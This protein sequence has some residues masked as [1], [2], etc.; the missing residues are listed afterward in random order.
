VAVVDQ[1]FDTN[2]FDFTTNWFQGYDIALA[3][4][5]NVITLRVADLAGNV[6]MTNFTV[7]LDY[8]T[9]TNAPEVQ[10]LWPTN[11]THL[12]GD[13]FYIRGHINDETATVV[14]QQVD[15]EGG[16][17]TVIGLVERNGRFWVEGL[18]LSAGTNE[19]ELI[20]TDAA[21]NVT[22]TNVSVVRS[23]V[24][25]TIT[26]TPTGES[27]YEPT[28]TVSGTISDPAYT[29]TV[30][31]EEAAVD[32]YGNWYAENVPNNGPGTA[33]FDVVV[34]PTGGGATV[35]L[36]EAVE[37]PAVVRITRHLLSLDESTAYGGQTWT[38]QYDAQYA[39]DAA[40]HGQPKYHGAAS[41]Y[42]TD[43]VYGNSL[44]RYQ[45]SD[46]DPL[47]TQLTETAG[48]SYGPDPLTIADWLVRKIPH[49]SF[50]HEISGS[51]LGYEVFYVPHYFAKGL[52]H[53]FPGW[54]GTEQVVTVVART[55]ETLFTGGKAGIARKALFSLSAG[56]TEYGK[57]QD[58]P[59]QNTP[60][61][62]VAAERIT[63]AGKTLGADYQAYMVLPE[64]ETVT[65][66]LRVQG[67]KHFNTGLSATK[68][69]LVHNTFCTALTNPDPERTSLGVGEYVWLFFD[70]PLNMTWPEQ[71]LWLAFAGS[72]DTTFGTP[73]V[74]TAPS[75][76][77]IA[78]VRVL[79]RDEQLDVS[80]SVKEP[81]GISHALFKTNAAG[82]RML[83]SFTLS[84]AGMHLRPYLAPTDVSFYRI[85]C[86]EIGEDASE[87]TGYYLDPD[88]YEDP[89]T[90]PNLSH[91]GSTGE[92]KGDRWFE[93]NCDNSWDDGWDRAWW[94]GDVPPWAISGQY[95]GGS[96]KW[97]IPGAWKIDGGQTNFNM[98]P[99]FQRMTLDGD[100]S[101]T[102]E[103]FGRRVKRNINNVYEIAE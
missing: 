48:G 94:A 52:R 90:D 37:L 41:R 23:E 18:P 46:A 69:K 39:P 102:I 19:W 68:H 11:D 44:T 34:E 47:G 2:K 95:E 27:L 49:Q 66:P 45:W 63:V 38:K 4:N 29:V 10:L 28:G 17:N 26:S 62:P 31:G 6:T 87:I 36:S 40:G 51:T 97:H 92:G 61:E 43:P 33:T 58:F 57:P 65:L 72:V 91:K 55:V 30:N 82:Q 98:T 103:K 73:V 75:N 7:I 78:M 3:T 88:Y 20:A 12:S 60:G 35:R 80:F 56:A 9:A 67:A 16:T 84:G 93:I 50:D 14:A 53:T 32:E 100:G 13:S 54:N 22:V 59:W 15:G 5:E 101:M 1:Y 79:V 21:G 99:W 64:N 85:L 25:I 77:T 70:P 74:Y 81:S 83:D 24:V 76:A 89:Y 96:F 42:A 8:S 71:P 86:M